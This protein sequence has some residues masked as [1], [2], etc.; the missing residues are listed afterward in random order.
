MSWADENMHF[1]ANFL[2]LGTVHESVIQGIVICET[3]K[4]ISLKES[5]LK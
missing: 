1:F 4:T 3:D 5:F 2:L